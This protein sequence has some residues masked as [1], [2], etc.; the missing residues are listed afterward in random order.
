MKVR[1]RSKGI[2]YESLHEDRS[3]RK[4]GRVGVLY[5]PAKGIQQRSTVRS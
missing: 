3:T 4:C 1:V 5:I 2:H